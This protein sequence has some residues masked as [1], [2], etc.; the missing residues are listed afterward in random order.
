MVQAAA[1][2]SKGLAALL[3]LINDTSTLFGELTS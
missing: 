3:S 2:C 1:Y